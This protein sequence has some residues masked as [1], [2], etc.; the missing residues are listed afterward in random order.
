MFEYLGFDPR[1]VP[2]HAGVGAIRYYS[3]GS[4]YSR[5]GTRPDGVHC[6]RAPSVGTEGSRRLSRNRAETLKAAINDPGCSACSAN[7]CSVGKAIAL[8]WMFNFRVNQN[9]FYALAAAD[10]F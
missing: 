7:S 9:L 10:T 3:A 6:V 4:G 8:C 5:R 2:D 1:A